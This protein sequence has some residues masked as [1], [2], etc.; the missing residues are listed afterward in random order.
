MKPIKLVMQA[1]GPFATREEIEFS[2]LGEN[3][4]FLINGVTGSGKSSI[5]DAICFALYG[6]TTDAARE[7]SSMR[8]DYADDDLLTEL[9]FDF[10]LGDY[11]YRIRRTPKQE[12]QKKR[13]E[14]TVTKQ[15]EAQLWRAP[16]ASVEADVFEGEG[17]ELLVA[18]KSTEANGYIN[19]ITGLN[20]EQFR[21]VMVLPQGKFRELLLAESNQREAIFSQLFQ[22]HIYKK[23]EDKLKEQSAEIRKAREQLRNKELGLLESAEFTQR[24]ELSLEQ[25]QLLPKL[26]EQ[27]A[28]VLAATECFARCQQSLDHAKK[29]QLRLTEQEQLLQE[30][31]SLDAQSQE[32]ESWRDVLQKHKDASV[33]KP[34]LDQLRKIESNQQNSQAQL[35]A[36]QQTLSALEAELVQVKSLFSVAEKEAESVSVLQR[37][38]QE[39]QRIELQV[40]KLQQ[41]QVRAAKNE[42]S[43]LTSKQELDDI[44]TKMESHQRLIVE[45]DAQIILQRQ[46]LQELSGVDV[47][48]QQL[49]NAGLN[50]RKLQELKTQ[51]QNNLSEQ[52]NYQNLIEAK[53]QES[54]RQQTALLECEYKWHQ[55]QAALLAKA[56]NVGEPCPVC[57]SCE[58]PHLA[59]DHN[60]VI[61]KSQVE[62]ERQK[63]QVL[64]D[65][66]NLLEQ[67]L[68][69]LQ[70]QLPNIEAHINSL[71]QELGAQASFSLGDMRAH[72]K[73]CNER[74]QSL[75]A[76][77]KNT[78]L[79]EARLLSMRQELEVLSV[80]VETARQSLSAV[81]QQQA[82]DAELLLGLEQD[83]DE[84]YRA[85]G[86]LSA[87]LA[88][89]T[90]TIAQL[91]SAYQQANSEI[92]R[93]SQQHAGSVATV[94][95]I[96]KDVARQNAELAEAAKVWLDALSN[97]Q[98]LDESGYQCALLDESSKQDL[99]DRIGRYQQQRDQLLG[100][101][102]Q[103][104][105][106]LDG[107]ESVAIEPLQTA[108][109]DGL[110]KKQQLDA[111]L[112]ALEG[113]NKQLL[114]L[115]Q[116][117]EASRCESERLDECY[118]VLGTLSDVAGGQNSKKISLQRF[119]L[120]VLLDDVLVQASERLKLMS[121]GRY[122]LI[123]KEERAKG[124]K[125]SG[126]ELE[127]EDAYTG[128]AR[129][130][131]TLSGGESFMAALSMALGLSDVV[132]A[133]SGGIKL[134]TLF[135]DEGFGSLD[136]ESLELALRTLID[137]QAS[138]RTIGVISHVTELKEQMAQRI[139]VVASRK[140]SRVNVTAA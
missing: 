74:Y 80:S 94:A 109:D 89:L 110:Y 96:N 5:L 9:I 135:I 6:Q 120:S 26:D 35:L 83:V 79:E 3:P 114:V 43:R 4:L 115:E 100:R 136:Q 106:D 126:L 118:G 91:Q 99:E 124:N 127:V 62:A 55:G 38:Q 82:V 36:E 132:Q 85:P 1:F 140:G 33:I 24:S 111:A 61:E 105:Q 52:Q 40:E 34:L 102:S 75:L 13:G 60:D 76:L 53:A 73:Q 116:K 41:A 87:E 137:L 27:R 21:Q 22:T 47:Q 31:K 107:K 25:E 12:Q 20:V 57:G 42:K 37:Q 14:G 119:V 97:S 30:Q 69:G 63:T 8:C 66:L 51:Q 54:A 112:T 67:H 123:R 125:A 7:G 78:L 133:Y 117:L 2:R 29:I 98:F 46:Q 50:L 84:R 59:S 139:D 81:T 88:A 70:Q 32:A 19:S 49:E 121:Q 77:E 28:E 39:F 48:L 101:L 122:Q 71:S 44:H 92:S 90:N 10:S 56:L 64:A 16:I 68:Y 58:H 11:Q 129:P 138:G 103:L 15:P 86:V 72:Y 104:Q 108:L 131:A 17:S 93:V 113:R 65:E 134:D 45:C 128:K 23:I 95:T 18:K 130:V